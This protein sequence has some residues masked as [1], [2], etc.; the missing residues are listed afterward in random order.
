MSAD[1]AIEA[2]SLYRFFRAGEEETLALR[3]VSLAVSGGE[4]VVVVGPSG[5]GKSTLLACLAGLDEPDGGTVLVAGRRM[6]HRPEPERARMRARGI[7]VM[8][9]SANLFEHLTVRANLAFVHTVAG[10]TETASPGELLDQVGLTGRADAYPG[11]L[12]GGEAARAGLAVALAG[13]PVVVLADEPTGE[14][15]STTEASVLALLVGAARRGVAVVVASHSPAVAGAADRIMRL[16]DG[17]V[18]A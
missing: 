18:A 2:R 7:G 13:S 16:D 14:L 8:S 11:E 6:S 1:T 17:R 15:D 10:T 9:Q 4:L 5:S 3:G 12:S